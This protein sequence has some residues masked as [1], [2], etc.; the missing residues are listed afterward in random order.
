[1]AKI[2]LKDE[3]GAKK[4]RLRALIISTINRYIWVRDSERAEVLRRCAIDV[5]MGF[6]KNGKPKYKRMYECEV[7]KNAFEKLDV[8]HIDPRIDPLIGWQSFDTWVERTFVSAEK[9][10][11]LC[12]GCHDEITHK[13]TRIGKD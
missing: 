12:E 8:H 11:G 10:Q 4:R 13:E 3:I 1:M 5:D 6:Y 2:N 9:L 7:C